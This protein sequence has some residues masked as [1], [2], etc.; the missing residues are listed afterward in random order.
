M[1]MIFQL[2]VAGFGPCSEGDVRLVDD[3]TGLL[4]GRYPQ[5]GRVEVCH[6]MKWGTICAH[7]FDTVDA[8]VVCSQL[9]FSD[10]GRVSV[11]M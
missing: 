3:M 1:L 7:S 6:D 9:G 11:T 8:R 5:K 2:S 10:K 4:S